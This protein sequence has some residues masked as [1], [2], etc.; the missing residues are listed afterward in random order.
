MNL[1]SNAGLCGAPAVLKEKFAEYL[2][3]F[4]ELGA[5][6]GVTGM[7]TFRAA[8]NI[9]ANL[10]EIPEERLL[11]ETDSPYLAPVPFRG[12]ENTPGLLILTAAET[13]RVRGMALEEL[14]E[15]TFR[16][17]TAF[18]RIDGGAA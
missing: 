15:L 18:Y 9:R 16:N 2:R 17:A 10:E 6:V 8:A 12:R 1:A 4:V 5:Y 11:I 13:A 7:V 3:R 14:A